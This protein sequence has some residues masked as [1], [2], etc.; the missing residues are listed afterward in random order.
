MSEDTLSWDA[1][2]RWLARIV[3]TP[4]VA[5]IL[6]IA[7]AQGLPNP[8]AH[9]PIVQVGLLGLALLVTG[10][11]VGWRWVL[12]GGILALLGWGL[13]LV[14]VLAS[15]R[16]IGGF[17]LALALPGALYLAS[18]FLKRRRSPRVL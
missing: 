12:A 3:G 5:V 13:F 16:P 1:A 11:L 14:P 9:P 17:V 8:F 10:I 2:C 6:Y 4:L 15:P 7:I 18:A